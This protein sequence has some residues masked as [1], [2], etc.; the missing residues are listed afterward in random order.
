MIS[1]YLESPGMEVDAIQH[2]LESLR[3]AWRERDSVAA[4]QLFTEG[5][6]YRSQP[7]RTP[8]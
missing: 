8:L 5:A 7:F 6:V 4:T 2:W 3:Y 1:G